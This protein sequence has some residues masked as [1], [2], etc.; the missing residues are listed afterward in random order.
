MTSN[1]FNKLT[2]ILACPYCRKNLHNHEYGIKCSFCNEEFIFSD[3]GQLDFR[4]KSNKTIT[5]KYELGNRL[6]PDNESN[7]TV[8]SNNP[9]PELDFSKISI[10]WHITK[11]LLSYFPKA[12]SENSFML[13][14]GCG[15]GIHKGI[16]EYAGFEYVGIDS[17]SMDASMLGDAQALPFKDNSFEFILSIAVLEHVQYPLVMMKE[18]Q[19][20][21]KPDGLIIGTVAFLEPFH[22]NSFYHH[23]HLGIYN[24]LKYVGLNVKKISPSKEWSVLVAQAY[25]SLFPKL[26]WTYARK[27][28]FLPQKLH[29]LWWKYRK[30]SEYDRILHT[31]G[32]F[33]FIAK[34]EQ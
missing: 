29:E 7:F 10:P 15:R 12:K 27:L 28:I 14:L 33:S 23:S 13:D 30:L 9:Y 24:S 3:L 17:E 22:S 19:R 31:T 20:V 4:L 8:L 16:C 32:A 11:E 1:L 2:D 25:M 26:K 21:L 6:I 18:I 5:L 34:K